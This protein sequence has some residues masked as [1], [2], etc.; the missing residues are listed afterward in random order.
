M[1][2]LWLVPFGA[3]VCLL[4]QQNDTFSTDVNVVNIFA[5]VHD[6]KLKPV[7]TLGQND[8]TLSE[9]GHPQTIR[10]FSRETDL[11]LTLGLLIDTSQSQAGVLDDEKNASDRFLDQVLRP[12]KDR[13]FVIHFDRETELL[14]DLTSSLPDL[15]KAIDQI[16]LDDEARPR[17]R[18]ASRGQTPGPVPQPAGSRM[19]GTTLY[20]AVFLASDELLKSQKGRKALILL[21]DG[22]DRGSKESLYSAIQSAQRS[23]VLVYSIWFTDRTESNRSRPVFGGMGG[24][25]GRRGGMGGG[26]GRNGGGGSRYPAA[27]RGGADGKKILEQISSETGGGFFEVTKKESISDIYTRIQ[28][29]LR[30][31]YSIGYV[32]DQTAGGGSFRHIVLTAKKSGLTVQAPQGYYPAAALAPPPQQ[33]S[34]PQ[35]PPAGTE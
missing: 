1:R 23:G 35:A 8:F 9:D 18:Q 12:E 26:M 2:L 16:H 4:A 7:S 22:V 6:K 33:N 21:T 20:D 29:E 24:G 15:H 13:T 17:L 25:M 34:H 31:Q 27:Q 30:N 3:A 32:S 14:Q 11:P 5:S 10:Y 28:E 19:G